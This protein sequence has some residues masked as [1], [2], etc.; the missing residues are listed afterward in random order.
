[1]ELATRTFTREEVL[2]VIRVELTHVSTISHEPTK[3]AAC[4]TLNDLRDVFERME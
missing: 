2:T 3:K 4:D 1:V